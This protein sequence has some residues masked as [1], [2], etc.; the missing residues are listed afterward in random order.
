[1]YVRD[2]STYKRISE[3]T[4]ISPAT[5]LRTVHHLLDG[6]TFLNLHPAC[7]VVLLD[8]KALSIGGHPF[9]E[10]LVWDMQAGLLARKLWP[11]GESA[12]AYD[13]LLTELEGRGVRITS[14]TTDGFP[15][16]RAVLQKHRLIQQR[17][18]VHLLRDLRVGLQLTTR[19]R[20]KRLTPANRQKRVIY[21]YAALFLQSHPA[22]G[23][24]R[25]RHLLR[26][27]EMNFFGLNPIQLQALRRFVRGTKWAF[28]H[29]FEDPRIPVTTNRLELGMWTKLG[30][31]L[32]SF[33][34]L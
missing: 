30:G 12:K 34:L 19:H 25:E 7:G 29:Y 32:M 3:R 5:I 16:L 23:D 2:R 20:R 22:T 1:M 6:L 9:C 26:Q 21:A 17:C 31:K 13:A 24:L 18:H 15:G 11:G 8:A 10:H 4:G 27:L 33:S 14:A 28:Q